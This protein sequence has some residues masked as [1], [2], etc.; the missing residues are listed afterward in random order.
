MNNKKPTK[1]IT[2]YQLHKHGRHIADTQDLFTATLMQSRGY[3]VITTKT[4][5]N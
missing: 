1:Y 5:V 3:T 2:E 4:A